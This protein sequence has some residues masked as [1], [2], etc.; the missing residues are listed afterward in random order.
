MECYKKMPFIERVSEI[1]KPIGVE[2]VILWDRKANENQL[3]NKVKNMSYY[4][5]DSEFKDELPMYILLDGDKIIFK[6][7]EA[8]E[9][10]KRTFMLEEIGKDK[11]ISSSNNYIRNIE[12]KYNGKKIVF[13]SMEGCSD[14]KKAK[15]MLNKEGI[16]KENKV[17]TIYTSDSN[18][19]KKIIDYEN[20][21]ANIYDIDWYPTFIKFD[22]DK[23]K[24]IRKT[25]DEQLLKELK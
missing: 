3:N 5:I 8:E 22:R 18:D 1:Y 16:V 24:I 7:S 12:H 4:L 20:V 17:V 19:E 9:I 25:D 23:Y 15:M 11:L 2:V 10:I 13:F 14:C 6:T 21:F